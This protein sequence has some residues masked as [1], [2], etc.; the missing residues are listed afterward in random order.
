MLEGQGARAVRI[1]VV[2]DHS[3][4][5]R[6]AVHLLATLGYQAIA[7]GNASEAEQIFPQDPTQIEVVMLDLFLGATA[8]V[9]RRVPGALSS[10]SRRSAALRLKDEPAA[11]MNF[12]RN[13]A[14]RRGTPRGDHGRDDPNRAFGDRDSISHRPGG[15][16]YL[17]ACP[18][19]RSRA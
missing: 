11:P 6:V 4:C 16:R 7:A 9:S 19:P 1:L 12:L 2:D 3:E 14:V 18:R 15:R 17:P 8:A 10:S 5:R 13:A